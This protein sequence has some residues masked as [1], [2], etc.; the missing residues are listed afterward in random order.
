MDRPIETIFIHGAG[1]ALQGVGRLADGRAAFVAGAL[2]E[3]TVQIEIVRDAQR[4][5]EGRLLRVIEPSKER[6]SPDCPYYANC[7]GC[8]SRHMKYEYSLQLKRQKVKDAL[9]RIGGVENANV[10]ET[11][12]C[13]E[14]N[15]SRN[16][17]EYA[18]EMRGG[19]AVIGCFG[20]KS[21]RVV[22]V[23]DC[24]LQKEES[25]RLLNW[26]QKNLGDY[27]CAGRVKTIVTRV[28]RRGEM[29]AVLSADAPVQVELGRMAQRLTA[30]LPE[31]KSLYLC[32]L[33]NRPAHALDGVC[34][35]IA[36]EETMLDN[37]LGL[38]F[39]LSP[40]SFLQVN[41]PQAEKLYLK[42]L[43]AAGLEQGGKKRV[44]D[45]YCGAGTITLAAARLAEHALGVE[46]VAP[47]I[48]NAKKNALRN[49]LAERADF[50]CADAAREIPKRIAAGEHF[51]AAILDP[52]RKGADAALL[53]ALADAG[54]E[55]IAYVSCDPATLARDVKLLSERG[56]FLN[57]AQPVDM[58]PWTEHVE[59]ACQLSKAQK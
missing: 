29:C 40:Q 34:S 1:S 54:I 44:L 56:Y 41:P 50:V 24:L 4:F 27:G 52:P 59:V 10:L 20:A 7:G 51:D 5:C 18:V 2:P 25:V 31:V 39:E 16:K 12:G 47:A 42:A 43:E 53:H 37:L 6:I 13:E 58:F 49:G 21:R 9:A 32:K 48:A 11:I 23:Q 26:M 8:A 35:R 38:E 22:R 55:R 3:E 28:N 17:A 46:I 30:E 15:R 19:E 33:K 36:G 45:A 57:W 14:P